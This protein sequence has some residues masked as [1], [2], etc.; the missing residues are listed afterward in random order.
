M[1]WVGRA[2][3]LASFGLFVLLLSQY[4]VKAAA[5]DEK[6]TTSNVTVNVYVSISLTTA[7]ANGVEFG[8]LDPGTDDNPSTT[9]A[10]LG[11]NIS[12]SGDTNVNVDILMKANANLTR[13]PGTEMIGW[14]NY[15]W[16][17]TDG[18]YSFVQPGWELNITQYDNRTARKVGDS[19]APGGVRSWQA[20]LDI[21][22]AQTAGSYNN[23]LYF[24][25]HQE[26]S[27]DCGF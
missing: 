9:C 8:N 1:K 4:S 16:N 12:V 24:C 2:L 25:A 11:C 21:P 18:T 15:T 23:T 13:F 26:D 17:S 22:P 14:W 10:N 5:S 27:T 3:L 20:W 6:V 7:F 19:V